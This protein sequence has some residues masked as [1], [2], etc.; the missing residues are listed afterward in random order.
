MRL[1]KKHARKAEQVNQAVKNRYEPHQDVFVLTSKN[2]NQRLRLKLDELL[3]MTSA[4]NY[5]SVA[6]KTNGAVKETLLRGTL[7]EFE[8]KVEHSYVRRCHRSFIVNLLHFINITGNAQG[9]M[10]H[11]RDL[12]F[13]I[14]VSRTYANDVISQ[15]E[16]L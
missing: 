9:Y 1:F 11:L 5:V 8:Q 7:K 13:A 6:Y 3:Y 16:Q 12:D 10:I 14:P 2:E 4:D 15:I